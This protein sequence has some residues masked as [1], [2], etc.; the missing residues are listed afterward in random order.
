MR[1][2]LA[3]AAPTLVLSTMVSCGLASC[4]G[5]ATARG[6]ADPEQVAARIGD[7]II[8]VA[9]VQARMNKQQPYVRARY[10]SAERRKEFLESLVQFEVLARAARERGYDRDPEVLRAM[11][12][13]MVAQL[14][15]REIDDKLKPADVPEA[16]VKK[17]LD[18][19]PELL[20]KPEEVRVSQ[21]L[22][23]DR[24]RANKVHDEVRSAAAQDQKGFRELVT[25]YS[26][27]EDSKQRGGDLTFFDRATT[28]YPKAI[29]EA[30]FALAQVGDVSAPVP[31]DKGFAILKLTQKRPGFTR[32][33]EEVKPT[34][35]R[36]LFHE[37][38]SQKM[39]EFI[40]QLR[41]ETKVEIDE[42]NLR[43]LLVEDK[44]GAA[45]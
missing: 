22:V 33:L 41:K 26:E 27:D 20:V 24:E 13:N 29:V 34:V 23:K 45:P 18:A 15:K 43:K 3:A 1:V 11:K 25:R 8:T 31:L 12:D 16:D 40:A 42:N 37:L 38:R 35:Q 19:H 32:T 30:A 9:D 28:M 2:G 39:K 14:I 10:S 4:H 5:G 17:H 36:Q 21:I 7:Q 44:T 6:P